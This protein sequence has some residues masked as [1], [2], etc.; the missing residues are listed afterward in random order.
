[1]LCITNVD[2]SAHQTQRVPSEAEL[3]LLTIVH[4]VQCAGSSASV[5]SHTHFTM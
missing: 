3:K 4:I 1:M 5:A 2:E